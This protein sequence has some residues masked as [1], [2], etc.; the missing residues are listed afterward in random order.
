MRRALTIGV[1]ALLALLIARAP[2]QEAAGGGWIESTGLGSDL[3]EPSA[4]TVLDDGAVV[5]A[6]LSG[7]EVRAFEPGGA[8]RW[9][10]D[11]FDRP[12]GLGRDPRGV[13]VAVAGGRR[14][15]LLGGRDGATLD[16][17]PIDVEPIDVV[18]VGGAIWGSATPTDR[19][20]AFDPATHASHDI[21]RPDGPAWKGPRGLE[22]DGRGGAWVTEVFEGRVVHLDAAGNLLGVVGGWG[23]GEGQFVKPKAMA[24]FADGAMVVADSYQ[25]ILQILDP[26]GA[27][28]SLVANAEGPLLLEHPID[29]AVDGDAIWIAD[30]GARALVRVTR[31][32]SAWNA[33]R[34]PDSQT[35]FREG[36]VL[37]DRPD[38]AC[39]QCHDGT[40]SLPAGNWDPAAHQHP[41]EVERGRALPSDVPRAGDGSLRCTSCHTVHALKGPGLHTPDVVDFG[42]HVPDM[43]ELLAG[44]TPCLDCHEDHLDSSPSHHRTSHPVGFPPPE[45][46]E[47][48][49]AARGIAL[50]D[51]EVSCQ[52]C[53]RAHGSTESALLVAS[54]A[55]GSLCLSCH[56]DHAKERSVHP[57][58]VAVDASI[59]S[60]VEALGGSLAPDGTLAC[61]GC[62]DP[63]QA[64]AGSLLRI[65]GG[66]AAACALC[67]GD[68]TTV[69]HGAHRD[70]GC[71]TCHGMHEP[72]VLPHGE[73]VAGVGPQACLDCHTTDRTDRHVDLAAGHP[74]GTRVVDAHGALP[75]DGGRLACTTC[76]D[77]HGG[78]ERLLRADVGQL[79]VSCH[80]DEASVLGTDHDASLVSVDGHA[81]PCLS[82]HEVHGDRKTAHLVATRGAQENPAVGRCLTCHDG[83]TAATKVA[84]A[85]HPKGLLL[86]T[87][88][89]PFRYSGS[90]PY[91]D[92]HGEPTSDRAVGEITCDTCHDV[93]RWKHDSADVAGAS[94]G[95]EQDSFLRDPDEVVRFC[96]VCHGVDARPRYRFFHTDDFRKDG[97]AA[98][99]TP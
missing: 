22:S 3:R 48:A 2:A 68:K 88:G 44:S 32:G 60:E 17:I 4:V 19:I 58:L 42:K 16:T 30:G 23:L 83:S 6:E 5:V 92:A 14:I 99:E 66:A 77:P 62:H 40:R 45:P 96:S 72:P 71:Q 31:G 85:T 33:G 13:W 38:T 76:H 9:R 70:E 20:L 97:S 18:V 15:E 67:H 89:L 91:S 64:T 80:T 28:V 43:R 29:L 95:S 1:A 24:R 98:A 57:V 52:S 59:R 10:R 35:L 63:H 75:L 79:C 73:R 69:F 65:K 54:A 82:C 49:M 25:G 74:V 12:T 37:G 87:G 50:Q 56:A 8:L 86:T 90:V 61:L 94:E 81:E 21:A 27:F 39:R 53:H 51:G 34:F 93:H 7:G 26:A 36:S 47:S 78:D 11:A 46:D 84:Y 55:D 41:L